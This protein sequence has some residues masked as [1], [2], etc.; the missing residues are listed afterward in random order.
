MK[1]LRFIRLVFGLTSSPFV[2]N[3]TVKIHLEKFLSD[4]QNKDVIIKLLRDLY[5]DHVTSSFDSIK[6]GIQF[7]EIS[8]SCL[9]KGQFAS[10]KWI[11]NDQKLQRFIDAKENENI[12]ENGT[13]RKVLGLHWFT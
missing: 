10:R 1:L 12:V 13:Y 3:G 9:L 6:E 8:E 7:Y 4:N 11:T 5:V 2:L